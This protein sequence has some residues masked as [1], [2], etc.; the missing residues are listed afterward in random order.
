MLTFNH[1]SPNQTKQNNLFCNLTCGSHYFVQCFNWYNLI[2][3]I[4]DTKTFEVLIG[5]N[6]AILFKKKVL[7]TMKVKNRAKGM[8]VIIGQLMVTMAT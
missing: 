8:N 2:P 5:K 1:A 3:Y 7:Q 6:Y 4:F